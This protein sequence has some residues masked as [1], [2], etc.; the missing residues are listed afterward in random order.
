MHFEKQFS[1]F[2]LLH[3]TYHTHHLLCEIETAVIFQ[4]FLMSSN[5]VMKKKKTLLAAAVVVV[6]G[7]ATKIENGIEF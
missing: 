5:S 4:I 6:V 7:M 2:T 3:C 1:F